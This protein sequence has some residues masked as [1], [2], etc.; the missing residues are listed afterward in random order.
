M[1][2]AACRPEDF[3]YPLL[4][5]KDYMHFSQSC[6][7]Y[8]SREKMESITNEDDLELSEIIADVSFKFSDGFTFLYS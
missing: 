8:W 4:I 6:L 7:G 5:S 1:V 3:I 2:I